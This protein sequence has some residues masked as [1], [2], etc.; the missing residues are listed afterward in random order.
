MMATIFPMKGKFVA[1]IIYLFRVFIFSLGVDFCTKAGQ[2]VR[3][4]VIFHP[5]IEGSKVFACYTLVKTM[6]AANFSMKGKFVA[7]LIYLGCYLFFLLILLHIDRQDSKI[8]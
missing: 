7:L 4:S 6:M 5:L 8:D 3:W 2:M 1:I